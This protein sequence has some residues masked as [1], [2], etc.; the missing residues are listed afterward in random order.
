[1]HS[2]PY[3]V[4][5]IN[6]RSMRWAGHVACMGRGE[7]HYRVLVGTREGRRHLEDPGM[8]GWIILKWIFKKWGGDDG[9]D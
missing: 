3:I 8:D 4:Q 2:S 7:V 6:S 5:V 1:M 9:L